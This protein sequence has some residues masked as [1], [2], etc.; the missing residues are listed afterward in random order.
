MAGTIKKYTL[1]EVKNRFIGESGTPKREQY[2]TELKLEV[3]GEL[4]R[5]V[6]KANE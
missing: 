1:G 6:R 3:I 2:E 4:I 5:T